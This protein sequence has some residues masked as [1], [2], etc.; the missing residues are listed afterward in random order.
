MARTHFEEA[1]WS[2]RYLNQKT[3]WDIGYIS[4]PLKEYFD[5]LTDKNVK[6][7]IPGCGNA[8]EAAYLHSKGFNNIHLIDIS[9]VPLEKFKYNNP[10]FPVKNIHHGDFF[11]LASKFDLIIEQTFFCALHPS[12]RIKYA[13]K[14]KKLLSLK[15]KLV[16]IL[17]NDTLNVDHP[18]FGGTRHEYLTLFR[19]YFKNVSIEPCYN[20][21]KPRDGRELFIRISD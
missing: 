13:M 12:E 1:Y 15:G 20:S 6:I 10:S 11:E 3:Q 19:K 18:P 21:I 9:I 14:V 17:F 7:L 16:G 2:D 4:T 5:Q 8:Y